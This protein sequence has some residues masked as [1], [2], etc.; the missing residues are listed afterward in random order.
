[1]SDEQS[2]AFEQEYFKRYYRNYTLQNPP[3]KLAYYRRLLEYA[4][5]GEDRPRVLELGCA[6]GR[7]L[8]NLNHDWERCGLDVSEY[9][10]S[11]ARRALPDSTFCVSTATD[12]P[13]EESFDVIAAFDVFEHVPD[14]DRLR[15]EIG[16]R[17]KPEGRLVF[18]VPVYDGVTGPII[19]VLDKDATHVHKKSRWFWLDWANKSFSVL[20]WS[21][22]YRYL[23][24]TG[25]YLHKPTFLL[26]RFT[27]AVAIVAK[28]AQG[29]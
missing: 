13:F 4:A 7:V 1:M 21:G 17:L 28:Q 14:L 5:Q 3:R 16:S 9:A 26:R 15:S 8:S 23:L 27:P 24:P 22:I 20:K 2:G 6:F 18:V 12:I 19:R 29:V 11:E 10:I 25:Y